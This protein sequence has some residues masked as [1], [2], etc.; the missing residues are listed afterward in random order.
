MD[1][2]DNAITGALTT[3][4]FRDMPALQ[5]LDLSYNAISSP[6]PAEIGRLGSLMKLVLGGNR[7]SGAIPPEI[8]ACSRLQLL[9]LGGNALSGA[10]PASI[11]R[12]LALE[13]AL[14]L[15]CNGLSGAI[16]KEFSGLVRLGVLDVS[17]N[18]LTGDLQPLSA[19]Q[20]LVSLNVSFNNLAGRAPDTPLFAKLPASDV[21]GNPSLCVSRCPGDASESP[22]G[23][24][25]RVATAVLLSALAALLAAGAFLLLARR[26]RGGRDDK[27]D[28]EMTPP[29]SVTLYQKLEVSVGDVEHSLI[30]ANVVGQGWSGSVYR[31]RVPSTGVTIAVK[32]FRS[33]DEAAAE[34]F[35]CEVGVLPRVRHRNVVRLLG[36][37]A[38]RRTRL[39]FYDYLPNGTLGGLLHGS[40]TVAAVV[41]WEVRFSIAVGVAEGLAYLHHDCVPPILH[42]DVKADNILLGDRYEACLADFGLARVADDGANSSPPPFAGS[43]GY[44]APGN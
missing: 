2:H 35:A 36:W 7:L 17:H 42:R 21:E 14:N 38:N 34:A 13:I 9:D 16:P 19:L 40:M 22:A 39:L 29:W 37:A 11:G 26:R 6:I 30:P 15:S 41:E 18:R 31:A 25:A 20:N 8:G 32:K 12:I 1:L 44:I 24:A 28:A 33:R 5:Y 4:L 3:G 43:Y 27:D 10:I 23:R